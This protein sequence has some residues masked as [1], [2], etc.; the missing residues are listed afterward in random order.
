MVGAIFAPLAAGV[1]SG[2]KGV[3]NEHSEAEVQETYGPSAQRDRT[4]D[5]VDEQYANDTDEEKEMGNNRDANAPSD[6]D[7]EVCIFLFIAAC[8]MSSKRLHANTCIGQNLQQIISPCS[9]Q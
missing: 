6:D 9:V 8:V 1:A 7:N 4:F 2:Y 3:I 5:N